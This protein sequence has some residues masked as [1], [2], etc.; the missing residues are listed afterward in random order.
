MTV[1]DRVMLSLVGLVLGV[2]TL[3]CA[4]RQPE[5]AQRQGRVQQTR[6]QR[7]APTLRLG[8]DPSPY[9]YADGLTGLCEDVK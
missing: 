2:I 8:G 5:R 3:S 7:C 6:V 1:G 9:W 4:A